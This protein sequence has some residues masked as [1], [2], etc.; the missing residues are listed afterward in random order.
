MPKPKV[1][2]QIIYYIST[3]VAGPRSEEGQSA[4]ALRKNLQERLD[5]EAPQIGMRDF[6]HETLR[7]DIIPQEIIL[8][9]HSNTPPTTIG[10][11]T[12][13]QLATDLAKDFAGKDKSQLKSITLASC[14]GGLG[15]NPLAKQLVE[16]LH[17]RGFTA[18]EV[19]AATHPQQSQ[20]GGVVSITTRAGIKSIDGVSQG[21]ATAI[22]YGN[23]MTAD[24]ERFKE[25]I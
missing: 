22:M 3:D 12:P 16:A 7:A 21:Q 6:A 5:M 9:A 23:Q 17:K 20:I 19:H 15:A 24:Y 8:L 1:V 10:D 18:V 13:E 2:P 11:R 25:L 14:E 4:T